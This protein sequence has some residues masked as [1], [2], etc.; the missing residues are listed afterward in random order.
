MRQGRPWARGGTW[1]RGGR[2][3]VG[4]A[5]RALILTPLALGAIST[6]LS[7]LLPPPPLG[8]GVPVATRGAS[9]PT[10]GALSAAPE[11]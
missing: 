6:V 10:A 1:V 2:G 8:S 3:K 11:E 7:I 5:P 4:R 9:L